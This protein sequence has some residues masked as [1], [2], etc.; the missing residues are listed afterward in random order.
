[1]IRKIATKWGSFDHDDSVPI[2]KMRQELTEF[3]A[4]PIGTHETITPHKGFLIVRYTRSYTRG[5]QERC[6]QLYMFIRIGESEISRY[7]P[8]QSDVVFIDNPGN[9]VKAAKRR[10]DTILDSGTTEE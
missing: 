7:G 4:T 6:T 5:N 3:F 2:W 10:V 9:S 1:M 8:G